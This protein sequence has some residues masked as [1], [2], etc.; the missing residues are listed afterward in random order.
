MDEIVK[1]EEKS[2]EKLEEG[3]V[4][5]KDVKWILIASLITFVFM[6]YSITV[7]SYYPYP[8]RVKDFW[9]YVN[10]INILLLVLTI[11]FS[12]LYLAEFGDDKVIYKATIYAFI[13]SMLSLFV[14]FLKPLF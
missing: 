4:E 8:F 14:I 10:I 13:A 5:R 6:F 3:K 1:E 9:F 2:E 11:M 12:S 7:Y